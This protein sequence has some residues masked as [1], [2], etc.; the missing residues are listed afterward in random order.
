MAVIVI[1]AMIIIIMATNIYW[2]F[3]VFNIA[4]SSVFILLD[5]IFIKI[6]HRRVGC[7]YLTNEKTAAKRSHKLGQDHTL[8]IYS[9]NS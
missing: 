7:S 2:A 5:I 1:T 9:P 3:N 8:F 4:L 6:F